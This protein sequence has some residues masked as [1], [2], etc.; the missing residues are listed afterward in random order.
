MTRSAPSTISGWMSSSRNL[1]PVPEILAEEPRNAMF[2]S[3]L[4]RASSV[5]MVL[6][7]GTDDAEWKV[8][9]DCDRVNHVMLTLIQLHCVTPKLRVANHSV[10]LVGRTVF[11]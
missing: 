1:T 6:P 7:D 4:K 5:A 3:R 9:V 2:D 8:K 10:T 11:H